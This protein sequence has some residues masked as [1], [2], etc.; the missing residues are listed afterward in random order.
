MAQSPSELRAHNVM[1]DAMVGKGGLGAW[2]LAVA[3]ATSVAAAKDLSQFKKPSAA[4][5]RKQLSQEQF[6]VTQEA[7]TERSFHNEYWDQHEP[8]IY[9]DVVSGEPL[10]SSLDKFDSGTGWPSFT[11]PLDPANIVR[12][13]DRQFF[14]VRTEVRSKH[15]DSHL[16]HVFDDGPKPTG[17]R[18]CMNSAALRFIPAAKLSAEGYA[19]YQ[20]LFAGGTP[21]LGQATAAVAT[22]SGGL[23]TA[24]FAGGCFW[25]M[26]KPFDQLP[27]VTLV[28]PGYTGGS[29]D[30]PTYEEV[31]AGGTGHAESVQVTYDPKKVSYDKLLE[32]FWH[33]IDPTTPNAQFCD[34]GSQYR[35]AIFYQTDAERQKAEASK[36]ELEKTGRFKSKIVTEITKASTFYPAEEYHQHYYKKN[37][38]R[39]RYYR[40]SCG[41]DQYLDSIWGAGRERD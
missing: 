32:V 15:A 33:Q 41:R 6:Q 28:L 4:E 29:K 1:G 34:H 20:P 7:A 27:G 12:R 16:G 31:S 14:S 9:V 38:V 21:A 40:H 22:A 37:P 19:D 24:V 5:L 10:F 3:F 39:Y 36:A 18:Y 30:K 26:E 11:K 8:G 17:Q 25:C 23:T 2:A 13:E 35:G